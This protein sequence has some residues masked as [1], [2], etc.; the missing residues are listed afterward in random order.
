MIFFL[1]SNINAQGLVKNSK[2]TDKIRKNPKVQKTRSLNMPSSAS[3]EKYTP[4]MFN[5]GA[6]HMCVAYSLALART[7][8]YARNNNLTNKNQI[9]AEAYSPYYI[10]SKYKNTIG[11]QFYSGLDMYFNKLNDYG[12]AK[13]KE[14]EYPHYY[15]FTQNHLWDFSVPTYTNLNLDYI[16]SEKFDLINCIYVDDIDD[17]KQQNDLVNMIKSEIIEERPVLF[18]MNIH[19]TFHYAN[20]F[21]SDT[22][23]TWCDSVVIKRKMLLIN[24]GEDYCYKENSNPSGRCDK[25]QPEDYYSGHAMTLIGFDDKKYNGAF[26]IQNSWGED[27]GN[28]GR[29]WIPYDVFVRYAEDIQSVD[30]APKSSFARKSIKYNFNYTENELNFDIKDFSSYLDLNW[31]L[32]TALS[33]E[34]ISES[35]AKKG[36]VILPNNLIIQGDFNNGLLEGEGKISLNNVYVYEG[37]FSGGFFEGEGILYKYDNW[38]DIVSERNGM[39]GGGKFL[40]GTVAEII[41]KAW[42]DKRN[43]YTYIGNFSDGNYNGQGLLS[44]NQHQMQ[45]K[46][47]FKNGYPV[48]GEIESWYDYVGQIRGLVPHGK[49]VLIYPNGSKIEGVF[50]YGEHVE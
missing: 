20:D 17:K 25:H 8:V 7:I 42:W 2:A 49:G 30:K 19:A 6:S 3:L 23:S 31:I 34:E 21:W 38:G 28:N 44:H 1:T 26:L 24:D 14:I 12:Y 15:P 39:F 33:I 18:S 5:Q 45:I 32:F 48:E 43:G 13:M 41:P 27:W 4:H 16:K 46:G 47:H 9:S 37:D 35:S 11:E 40:N 29:T 22:I 50:Y 36:Q 10:Y